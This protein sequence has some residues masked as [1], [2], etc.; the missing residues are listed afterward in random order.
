MYNPYSDFYSAIILS[1]KTF[2][3][4]IHTAFI[5]H[6]GIT[7]SCLRTGKY[8]IPACFRLLEFFLHEGYYFDTTL[9]PPDGGGHSFDD[10][11]RTGGAKADVGGGRGDSCKGGV[12]GALEGSAGDEVGD[13]ADDNA[14][15]DGG[16]L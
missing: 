6:S 12:P 1:S 7:I 10:G 2:I 13:S 15:I 8:N 5:L 9:W 4:G 14:G 11:A 16:T 3:W